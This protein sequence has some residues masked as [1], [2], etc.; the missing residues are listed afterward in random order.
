[1]SESSASPDPSDSGDSPDPGERKPYEMMSRD[2]Q[3]KLRKLVHD[4]NGELFLIRGYTEMSLEQIG[5][6]DLAN[7]N[8]KKMLDRADVVENLIQRLREFLPPK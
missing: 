6:N 3:I 4:L 2:Q 7:R 1:M 5:E 8:L